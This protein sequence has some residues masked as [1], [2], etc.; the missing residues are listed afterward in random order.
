MKFNEIKGFED[1]MLFIC[2]FT[3]SEYVQDFLDGN[4]YMNNFKQFVEQEK[5]TEYKGQGDSYE[6]SYINIMEAVDIYIDDVYVASAE[7][8]ELS[9][10][11]DYI[12]KIPLFSMCQLT[13]RD[14][15]IITK[16]EESIIIQLSLTREEINRIKEDFKCDKVIFTMDYAEFKR[17]LTNA[18]K[19]LKTELWSNPI[20]YIDFSWNKERYKRFEDGNLDSLFTKHKSL[21]YQREFRFVLPQMPVDQYYRFKVGDLSDMFTVAN[22]D[23]F[24]SGI[25]IQV[26]IA[27]V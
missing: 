17:R 27:T 12:S 2:K 13:S 6:G 3:K 15:E 8:T 26:N 16:Q 4:L 19:E 9:V 23:D 24:L 7:K 22:I 18:A 1:R 20:Q 25:K 10:S 5:R 21:E 14:F 11:N